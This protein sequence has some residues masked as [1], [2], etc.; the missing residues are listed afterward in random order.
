MGFFVAEKSCEKRILRPE[1]GITLRWITLDHANL[2]LNDANLTLNYANFTLNQANSGSERLKEP[3]TFVHIIKAKIQMVTVQGNPLEK[4]RSL[5]VDIS[6]TILLKI[7]T[8]IKLLFSNYFGR[9]SYS[10][11]ARQ[12][13]ISVTV[14]ALWVWREYVFTVTVRYSYIKNGTVT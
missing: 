9:Y 4:G 14:T 3:H 11:R 1:L 13:L 8:R 6:D 12:E 7:I 10:F 5:L 2:T